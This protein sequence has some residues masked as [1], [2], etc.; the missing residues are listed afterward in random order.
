MPAAIRSERGDFALAR[1]GIACWNA[2][3]TDPEDA[4]P[5]LVKD[6][7]A[8]RA[9]RS[10]L[11]CSLLLL[12]LGSAASAQIGTRRLVSG[13]SLPVFATAPALPGENRLFVVERAGRIRIVQNGTLLGTPFLDRT[14]C[15]PPDCVDTDGE[16]GM[17]GLAFSPTYA[18][19]GEFYVYY[20]AGDNS[21]NNDLVSRISRFQVIGDPATSNQA[22]VA[23]EEILFSLAQPAADNHKGGTIAFSD[24]WLYLAL[25]DG[26]F[27]SNTAQD[28]NTLLGKLLRFDVSLASP[29]PEV[30]AEGL[31]NPFRFSIDSLTGDIY[32]ADVGAASREEIDVIAAE[33]LS[34]VP[35]GQPAPFNFGWDVEEGTL[36][37]GPNPP[38]EPACG[39]TLP[40]V[41]EYDSSTVAR[42]AVIGGVVYRGTRIPSLYGQY[43]FGDL[44][45]REVWS[46]EWNST[47]GLVGSVVDRSALFDPDVG[48][49]EQLVAFGTDARGEIYPIDQLGEVFVLPEP[50]AT[51]LLVTAIG[52]L[53]IAGSPRRPRRAARV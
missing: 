47:Q 17:L 42:V 23:S 2:T 11:A 30:V 24:G 40:P 33:D 8:L 10:P 4:M 12:L 3:S 9:G 13:L 35:L 39:T 41:A 44:L 28:D 1:P 22:D 5:N 20:T 32:I 34:S 52:V 14:S 38:S 49:I 51:L 16:G 26:G 43:F 25:G 21:I 7:T 45:S 18:T 6:R 37:R 36:C 31:R 53:W 19:D 29:V 27:S 46:F 15:T 48:A 50:D